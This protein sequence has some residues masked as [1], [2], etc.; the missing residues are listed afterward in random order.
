MADMLSA[1]CSPE[2]AVALESEVVQMQNFLEKQGHASSV[3][4]ACIRVCLLLQAVYAAY[5]PH[6]AHARALSIYNTYQATPALTSVHIE[7]A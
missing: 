5:S 6:L 7:T 4:A 1:V 3:S 2:L